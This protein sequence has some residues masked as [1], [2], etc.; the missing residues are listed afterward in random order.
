[1]PAQERKRPRGVVDTSVLVAG[2]AGL[3]TS[4]I[5]SKNPSA[6][7]RRDWIESNTF[8]WLITDEIVSEYKR[9]LA[10]LGV[11][12]LLIGK[13]VNLLREEA[14]LVAV[15]RMPDISPDP[16]DNPFC[17][18]AEQGK[19]DFIVTLNPKD[20]RAVPTDILDFAARVVVRPAKAPHRP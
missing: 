2:I 9:V 12:R 4:G 20:F 17:A 18:C 19:A 11:R 15:A 7:L 16:G 6:K 13:I 10:R 5:A 8:V 3:K 14:E 1:L